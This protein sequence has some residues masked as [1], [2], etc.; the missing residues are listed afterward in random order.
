MKR[1]ER[2]KKVE[3]ELKNEQNRILP[4]YYYITRSNVRI[5]LMTTEMELRYGSFAK[6]RKSKYGRG[7]DKW[8]I[9]DQLLRRGRRMFKVLKNKND[10]LGEEELKLFVKNIGWP[11]DTMREK[12]LKVKIDFF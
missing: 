10:L 9:L 3:T 5:M 12:D 7:A 2:T 1:S 6:Y 4:R 8:K 11:V